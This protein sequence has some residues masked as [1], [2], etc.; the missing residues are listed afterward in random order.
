MNIDELVRELDRMVEKAPAGEKTA[1]IILFGIR[2]Y[3][4]LDGVSAPEIARR[5]TLVRDS[6]GVEIAYGRTLGKYVVPRG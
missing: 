4:E 1:T 5:A 2:Y 3:R 6:F